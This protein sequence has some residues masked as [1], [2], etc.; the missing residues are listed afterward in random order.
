MTMPESAQDSMDVRV[1]RLIT[2][3]SKLVEGQPIWV[4]IA[5]LEV[6]KLTVASAAQE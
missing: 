4:S 1:E 5:A 2:Q 3:I 6:V